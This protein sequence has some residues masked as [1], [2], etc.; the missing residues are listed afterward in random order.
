VHV[1]DDELRREIAVMLYSSNRL[2]LGHASELCDLHQFEFQNILC[3]Q[4]I[5]IH[6]DIEEFERDL[7]VLITPAA[8]KMNIIWTKHAEERQQEWEKKL[9]ITR[10]EVEQV[11]MEPE[12]I[13]PGDLQALVAQTRRG[14]GLLRVPFIETGEER[15]ILTVYWTSKIERY[16]KET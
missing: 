2:T 4:K 5:P 10:G 1:S 12:Q 6:Y 7:K 3:D 9:G 11:L 15:R 16:W 13:V 8:S 14:N